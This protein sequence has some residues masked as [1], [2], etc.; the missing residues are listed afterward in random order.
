M[1]WTVDSCKLHLLSEPCYKIGSADNLHSYDRVLDVSHGYK[2]SVAYGITAD[3]AGREARCIVL[4]GGGATTPHEHSIAVAGDLVLLAIGDSVVALRAPSREVEW[5]RKADLATCF[6][7]Y[8]VP[9]FQCLVVHG[10]VT[11]SR[12][13]LS[14][15]VAWEASGRDIFTGSFSIGTATVRAEDFDGHRYE[16]DLVSGAVAG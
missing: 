10:E 9:E 16:I 4:S 11:I 1:E 5:H 8:Y 6:G 7:V 14:G 15:E 12:L 3:F 13:S 2:P